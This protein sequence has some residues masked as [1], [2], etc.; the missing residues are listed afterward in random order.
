MRY[1]IVVPAHN[2][3]DNLEILIPRLGTSLRL[4]DAPFELI[5]VDNASTDASAATLARFQRDMQFL[6]VVT[7]PAMGYGNAV[8]AG[9]NAAA[10]EVIGIIRADNQEKSEDLVRMFQALNAEK[11]SFYKAIRMHRMNDGLRRVIISRVYNSLFKLL[12]RLHSTDLNATPKVFDRAYLEAAHLES[13]DWFIDAEMVIKAEFLGF[14]TGEMGIEY[15]PRLKGKSNV[16]MKH[17][18]EFLG[19]MLS[20]YRRARHGKILGQ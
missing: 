17:V 5:I 19:N 18:F 3:S 12:F 9:L 6:R 10:G 8:L 1:S 20:W 13:K 11:V 16:R 15:L 14:K 4:L 2:E 7:E